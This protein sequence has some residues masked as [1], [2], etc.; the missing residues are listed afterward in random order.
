L[1][2]F[3]LCEDEEGFCF[4]GGLVLGNPDD[5]E[6]AASFEIVKEG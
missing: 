5:A 3:S 2:S 4:K 1:S 6:L